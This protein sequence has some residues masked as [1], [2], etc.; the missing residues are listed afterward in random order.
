MQG[1]GALT[2]ATLLKATLEPLRSQEKVNEWQMAESLGLGVGERV[3]GRGQGHSAQGAHGSARRGAFAFYY[4]RSSGGYVDGHRAGRLASR[5]G[6][7]ADSHAQSFGG[8]TGQQDAA[9]YGRACPKS[10]F[11]QKA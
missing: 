8:W 5:N 7:R 11:F 10:T 9:L 6:R 1:R 4:L 3:E 2:L